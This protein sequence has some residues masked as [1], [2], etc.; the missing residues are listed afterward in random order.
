MS[1]P[2]AIAL[3]AFIGWTL[4]LLTLME[5]LRTRLV[6]ARKVPANAFTSDNAN[7]SPFMQRLA[8]AHAN[9]IENLPVLGGL[10]LVAIAT[11]R[12]AIT[13]PLA[14]LL[15]GARVFQS[16]MH[17]ASMSALAVT[18]RFVAFAVQ[19]AIGLYWACLLLAS[20]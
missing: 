20:A 18:I 7:L 16:L 3:T 6:L 8:R 12:S 10:M 5:V 15:L 4:L 19:L 13:D 11:D 1:S 9:C 17:L 2:T 14:Y